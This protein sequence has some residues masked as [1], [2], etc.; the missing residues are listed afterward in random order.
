VTAVTG[1]GTASAVLPGVPESVGA[2]RALARQAL[3]GHGQ[4][5]AAVLA[6]SELV[7]NAICYTRSGLPGGTFAVSVA[8]TGGEV[9]VRVTDAGGRGAPALLSPES[10]EAEHGRGLLIVDAIADSW[11]YSPADAGRVTWCRIGESYA[12]VPRHSGTRARARAREGS[13]L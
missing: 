12:G 7:T 8:A 3:A 2:A 10:A 13:A 11:G 6:V 5:E 4:A 9:L 1:P